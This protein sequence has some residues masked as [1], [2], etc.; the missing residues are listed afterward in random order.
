MEK[1]SS[2]H[3]ILI[4]GLLGVA[5]GVIAYMIIALSGS[6]YHSSHVFYIIAPISY[7]LAC[8]F[9]ADDTMIRDGEQP[10]G[11]WPALAAMSNIIATFSMCYIVWANWTVPFINIGVYA[12]AA[13]ASG[14]MMI[15]FI[16][17]EINAESALSN[18][19]NTADSEVEYETIL[20]VILPEKTHSEKESVEI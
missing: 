9:S 5:L 4:V 16:L 15:S 13:T 8:L 10:R 1:L 20:D 6:I 19:S 3:R 11:I 7:L 12:L 17:L 18:N 2:I 14:L